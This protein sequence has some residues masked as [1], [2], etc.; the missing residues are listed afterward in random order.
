MSARL[1]VFLF[2]CLAFL[3]ADLAAQVT[4]VALNARTEDA[5]RFATIFPEGTARFAGTGGS[6]TPLGVGHTTLS[7]NPAG[8]AWSRNTFASV[9][10]GFSFTLMDARLRAEGV[11]NPANDQSRGVP[12]LPSLGVVIARPPV[13]E[14][15]HPIVFGLALNR[16]ADFNETIQYGGSSTRSIVDALVEDLNTPNFRDDYRIDIL[17]DQIEPGLRNLT[18]QSATAPFPDDN[19]FNR[20]DLGFLSIFDTEGAQGGLIRREGRVE[21]TGSMHEFTAGAAMN[22]N[23]RLLLG[24]SVGIPFLDFGETR[25]YQ[26][27]NNAGEVEIFEDAEYNETLSMDGNGFNLKLGAIFLPTAASRISF[28]VHTPTFWTLEETYSTNLSINYTS[29]D[30]VARGGRGVS[31][32]AL[33]VV[34][35]QTPWRLQAGLGHL[36]GRFGFLSVDAEYVNYKGNQFSF[37]DFAAPDDVT[38]A[39]IDNALA[40]AFSVRAGGEVNVDP[41]Q[42]RFGVGWRQLP[43]QDLRNG[44]DENIFSFSGGL[45]YNAG[46]F[47]IDVAATAVTQ[48]TY[49]APYRTFDFPGQVVDIDRFRIRGM[50]TVGY[51]GL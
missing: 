3:A 24:A 22:L 10:G 37:Q 41:L 11:A 43:V 8:I 7:T 16:L 38:N 5:L 12:T 2:A 47:F 21:R 17:T 40:G 48:N 14:D 15:Q 13:Y 19:L 6:M 45:G 33:T 23:N 35:L 50:I 26:E 18:V 27:F 9:T 25:S 42:V 20:D 51:R 29:L 46:L 32:E 30:G 36:V 31:P 39:Q 44:E 34:N 1:P 28:A 4:P 49:F